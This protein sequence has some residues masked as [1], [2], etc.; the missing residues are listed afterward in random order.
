MRTKFFV[1]VA[2]FFFMLTAVASYGQSQGTTA[3]GK[4]R[5]AAGS[6]TTKPGSG[7]GNTGGTAGGTTAGGT[8]KNEKTYSTSADF[9]KIMVSNAAVG[10]VVKY[11]TDGEGVK[12]ESGEFRITKS[13][14]SQMVCSAGSRK[15]NVT[16]VCTDSKARIEFKDQ[17]K[18]K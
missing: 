9:V 16:A 5:P 15:L 7:A 10:S 4:D 12:A 8:V 1:S 17:A 3:P 14:N 6:T 13:Q 18:C 2:V 11:K